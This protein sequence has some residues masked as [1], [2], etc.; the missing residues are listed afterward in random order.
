[1][2]PPISSGLAV[3]AHNPE[4]RWLTE[5][6]GWGQERAK[7]QRQPPGKRTL[8]TI[9]KHP[10]EA[11]L[12]P[13]PPPFPAHAN[14]STSLSSLE[15]LE[16]SVR[17]VLPITTPTLKTGTPGPRKGAHG[18]GLPPSQ[19]VGETERAPTGERASHHGVHAVR[20]GDRQQGCC[21][22]SDSRRH[23]SL[24]GRPG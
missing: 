23:T 20:L 9:W 8:L 24:P 1:M 15:P 22:R 10:P 21:S 5:S 18:P 2:R 17:P 14:L 13:A 6:G 7:G 4:C 12:C 19:G 3:E 16:G 11:P